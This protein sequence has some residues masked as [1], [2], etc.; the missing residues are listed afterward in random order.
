MAKLISSLLF[1]LPANMH[2]S[3]QAGKAELFGRLVSSSQLYRRSARTPG[4]L[5]GIWLIP[6]LLRLRHTPQTL[7]GGR[8]R[9]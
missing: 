4:F 8:E 5:C 7:L 2:S 6:V 1:S 9:N 3:S